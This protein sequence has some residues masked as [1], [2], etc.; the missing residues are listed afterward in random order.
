MWIA[1]SVS[2]PTAEL[3]TAAV[4]CPVDCGET[5]DDQGQSKRK[6]RPIAMAEALLK[7]AEGLAVDAALPQ[8]TAFLEPTQLGVATPDGS[9]VIIRA[10]R[11]WAADIVASAQDPSLTP[12]SDAIAPS[13]D[14]IVGLDLKNAYGLIFRSS[15]LEGLC[16]HVPELAPLAAAEWQNQGTRVWQV[17]NGQWQLSFT[18]RGGW[19][20]SRQ[21]QVAFCDGLEREQCGVFQ[22]LSR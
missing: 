7:F 2:A 5:L 3:W 17:V 4:I 10:I 16:H 12:R 6:L 11:S 9:P 8:L 14:A 19:Q 13:E 1:G 22:E 20:G 21:M 18:A 15:C